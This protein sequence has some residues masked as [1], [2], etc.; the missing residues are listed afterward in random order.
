MQKAVS[1]VFGQCFKSK[2]NEKILIIYDEKKRKI[3]EHLF[4]G[5]KKFSNHITLLKIEEPKINGAEPKPQ[6]AEEMLHNDIVLLVTSK[7]LSHTNARKAAS[8]K[9]VRIASMP[10][11]TEEMVDRTL[12]ADY[13]KIAAL[14]SKISKQLN[15]G[16]ELHISTAK[17]TDFYCTI[18]KKTIKNDN[19]DLSKKGSFHNLPSG[20]TFFAPLEGSSYGK[21]IVDLSHAEIGKLKGDITVNVAEGY[22]VS[23]LG[24]KEGRYLDNMLRNVHNKD[25]YNIAEVGIG[26]HYKARVTGSVLE[27][28]KVMGTCHIALGNNY[29]FGGKIN[30]PV[31]VDGV[32]DK[33]TIFVDKK[34]IMK[35]GKFCI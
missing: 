6:V 34:C 30:V 28:E 11:I 21:Y 15:K 19:G 9:G 25:A 18:N 31:H 24:G 33:P 5:G 17:G 3:A 10:G 1:T 12:N 20:E 32:I 29:S 35:D 14:C 22:A 4:S 26:T 7:S 13:K 23:I 27:D 2:K 8:K 16:K